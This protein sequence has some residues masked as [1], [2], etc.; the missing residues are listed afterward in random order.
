M[1][2]SYS[3]KG[4]GLEMEYE[5]GGYIYEIVGIATSEIDVIVKFVRYNGRGYTLNAI[6]KIRS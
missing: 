1:I 4:M 3:Q 2:E 6:R 5:K